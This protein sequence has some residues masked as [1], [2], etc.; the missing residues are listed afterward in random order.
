MLDKIFETSPPPSL[1]HW[2][3]GKGEGVKMLE[4]NPQI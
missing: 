4:E 1:S 3:E 2:G